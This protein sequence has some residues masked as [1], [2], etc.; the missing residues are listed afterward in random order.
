MRNICV[1]SNDNI[2][3]YNVCENFCGQVSMNWMECTGRIT[4]CFNMKVSCEDL[5]VYGP[6]KKARVSILT[7]EY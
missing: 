3:F 6:L 1:S 7:P 5:D 4:I 2:L